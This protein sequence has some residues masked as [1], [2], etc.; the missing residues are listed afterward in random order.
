MKKLFL[1]AALV[2]M[3]SFVNA[4]DN[5]QP[6]QQGVPTPQQVEQQPQQD[7]RTEA[8][9]IW[10]DDV[11]PVVQQVGSDLAQ[12]KNEVV[13]TGRDVFKKASRFWKK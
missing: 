12:A 10:N 5:D 3:T 7:D 2:S 9:K 8:S 6:Q 4:A 11:K 1:L 13:Q